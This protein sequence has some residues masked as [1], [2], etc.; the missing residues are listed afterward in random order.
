MGIGG[1]D[2]HPGAAIAT[3]GVGRTVPAILANAESSAGIEGFEKFA[4]PGNQIGFQY[5]NDVGQGGMHL[6]VPAGLGVELRPV[7]AAVGAAV[8]TFVGCQEHDGRVG[9][10]H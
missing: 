5:I 7:L 6:D 3:S 4:T 8:Q 9:R 2:G 1:F 10:V